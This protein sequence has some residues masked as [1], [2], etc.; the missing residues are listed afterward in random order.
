MLQNNECQERTRCL[1]VC[2]FAPL[3]CVTFALLA[4]EKELQMLLLFFFRITEIHHPL[5][6]GH[7]SQYSIKYSTAV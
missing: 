1:Y 2:T 4:A 7:S 5:L 6:S 3:F